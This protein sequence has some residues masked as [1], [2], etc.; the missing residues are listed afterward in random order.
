MSV[1][2]YQLLQYP[3]HRAAGQHIRS[4]AIFNL[5]L[6]IGPSSLRGAVPRMLVNVL[7]DNVSY[8]DVNRTTTA[9]TPE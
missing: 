2:N 4:F 5:R 9:L 8:K 6:M 3:Q 7:A 1:A